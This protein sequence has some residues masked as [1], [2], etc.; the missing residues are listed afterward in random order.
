MPP[1]YALREETASYKQ[2]ATTPTVHQLLLYTPVRSIDNILLAEELQREL[3]LTC[4]LTSNP[5]SLSGS[6]S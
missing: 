1:T 3:E 5:Q 6:P 4:Q 2:D